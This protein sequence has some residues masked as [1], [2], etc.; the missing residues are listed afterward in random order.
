MEQLLGSQMAKYIKKPIAVEAVQWLKPGDHPM[1]ARSSVFADTYRIRT[2]EG[3]QY[4]TP[5]CWILGPGV[6]GEY[7]PIQDSIFRKSYEPAASATPSQK[8]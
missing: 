8:G 5:G 1:V 6:E 2:P 3:D 4:V 7:W